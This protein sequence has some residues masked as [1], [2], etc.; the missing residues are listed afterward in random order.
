MLTLPS[1]LTSSSVTL[2]LLRGRIW[3]SRST[4]WLWPCR[5][6]QMTPRIKLK[7]VWTTSSTWIRCSK[8]WCSSSRCSWWCSM[9]LW[10]AHRLSGTTRFITQEL[11]RDRSREISTHTRVTSISATHR[12]TKLCRTLS[13][14]PLAIKRS[15]RVPLSTPTSFLV[16]KFS[17]WREWECKTKLDHTPIFI[18]TPSLWATSTRFSVMESAH[19]ALKVLDVSIRLFS[20]TK[21]NRRGTSRP[22]ITCSN[23]KSSQSKKNKIMKNNQTILAVMTS[24]PP[25]R[26]LKLRPTT[27][28][29][30]MNGL[31]SSTC[32]GHSMM[33]INLVTLIKMR[34]SHWPKQ[35]YLKLALTR[36]STKKFLTASLK[37]STAMVMVK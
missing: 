32:C 7:M 6:I 8:S 2:S 22:F 25:P 20:W 21:L 29:P 19:Q 23:S 4:R 16:P 5:V 18:K 1:K 12:T 36:L 28:P 27:A 37:R 31:P 3:S 34:L 24:L 30:T 14:W 35:P 17:I 10:M 13:T 33:P 9:R 26:W 15:A 11:I